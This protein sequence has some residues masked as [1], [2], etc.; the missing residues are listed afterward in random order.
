MGNEITKQYDVEDMSKPDSSGGPGC[1]WKIFNC[2]RKIG[3]NNNNADKN[4]SIFNYP[5]F[6]NHI[7]PGKTFKIC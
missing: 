3:N 5:L 4:V 6:F 2:K 7:K 1:L